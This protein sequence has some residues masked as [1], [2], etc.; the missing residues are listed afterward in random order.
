MIAPYFKAPFPDD[1]MVTSPIE[2][3]ETLD[4]LI[5]DSAYPVISLR[6]LLLMCFTLAHRQCLMQ[7]RTHISRGF[8][9]SIRLIGNATHWPW[10][11]M[12]LSALSLLGDI[13]ER[14]KYSTLSEECV[15]KMALKVIC[16]YQIAKFT[17]LP[18][19]VEIRNHPNKEV[20]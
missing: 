5:V 8:R 9:I 19:L 4:K 20:L 2:D 18:T 3:R 1:W 12:Y 10:S 16:L 17:S 7:E 11:R 14:T 13:I 6:T 15:A